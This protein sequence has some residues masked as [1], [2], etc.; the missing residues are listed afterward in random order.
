MK[1]MGGAAAVVVVVVVVVV[2][3]GARAGACPR[4]G[5]GGR[6][7]QTKNRRQHGSRQTEQRLNPFLS[8]VAVSGSR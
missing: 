6:H 8:S 5:P 3:V 1:D 4:P 2:K 7:S